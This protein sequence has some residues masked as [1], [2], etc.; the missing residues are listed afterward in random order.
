MEDV[1]INVLEEGPT[2]NEHLLPKR[3]L[4]YPVGE[5]HAARIFTTQVVPQF[6]QLQRPIASIQLHHPFQPT[7]GCGRR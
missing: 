6:G 5:N 4:R 3:V 2:Y 1:D 7:G